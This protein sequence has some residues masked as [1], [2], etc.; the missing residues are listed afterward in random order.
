MF[1]QK[2]MWQ[3]WKPF[4]LIST[5]DIGIMYGISI[6]YVAYGGK[7]DSGTDNVT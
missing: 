5:T 4:I 2:R 7:K 3:N 1:E 6:M